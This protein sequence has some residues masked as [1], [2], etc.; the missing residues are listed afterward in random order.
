MIVL[1]MIIHSWGFRMEASEPPFQAKGGLQAGVVQT[2]P[3]TSQQITNITFILNGWGLAI[4]DLNADGW[5]DLVLGGKPGWGGVYFSDRGPW[6]F[7]N[8]TSR[9]SETIQKSAIAGIVVSDLDSDGQLDLITST[10]D[11]GIRVIYGNG[12]LGFRTNEV[13]Y[14]PPKGSYWG[15][16]ASADIDQNGTVDIIALGYRQNRS[17]NYNS[18]RTNAGADRRLINTST[19]AP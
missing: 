17:R 3:I 9:L 18:L 16:M 7:T 11:S 12:R 2:N 6:K 10:Y 19:M 15:G 4:R 1:L 5:P 8:A 14:A 13:S